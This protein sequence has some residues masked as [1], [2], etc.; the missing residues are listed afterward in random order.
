ML[1]LTGGRCSCARKFVLAQRAV[2][3][4]LVAAHGGLR[5]LQSNNS[6]GCSVTGSLPGDLTAFTV[7][8]EAGIIGVLLPTAISV[9]ARLVAGDMRTLH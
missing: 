7:D 1:S 9:E 3:Y 6:K 4:G 8:Q 5:A 2:G